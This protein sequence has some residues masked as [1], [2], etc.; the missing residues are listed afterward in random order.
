MQAVFTSNVIVDGVPIAYGVSG[1]GPDMVLVHGSGGFHQWWHLVAPALETRWRLIVIDLSGHGDSGHRATRSD[2]TPERWAAEV[3]AVIDAVGA[4]HPVFVGHSMGGRIG[5]AAASMRPDAFAGL[6]LIDTNSG[7]PEQDAEMAAKFLGSDR[8]FFSDPEPARARFKL[9]PPQ[10]PVA[11][12]AIAPIRDNVLAQ[13]GDQW[14][15]KSDPQALGRFLMASV[16]KFAANVT[17]PIGFVYGSE[18]A[19]VGGGA[20]ELIPGFMPSLVELAEVPGAHHHVILD[21]PAESIELIDRMASG[22]V[23]RTD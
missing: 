23:G 22:F 12:E 11:E 20:L 18:S 14:S 6:V 3:L 10:P 1:T 13:V 19:I 8:K 15:W 9:L 4:E 5:L 7:T 21:H 2:Y 17:A 16:P